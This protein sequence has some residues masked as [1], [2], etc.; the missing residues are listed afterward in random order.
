MKAK[1]HETQEFAES[2]W[3]VF[4]SA[5]PPTPL[6]SAFLLPEARPVRALGG[7]DRVGGGARLHSTT[8]N[9][10]GTTRPRARG[11]V[12]QGAGGTPRTAGSKSGQ[13]DPYMTTRLLHIG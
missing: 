6:D 5:P 2:R 7:D 9:A 12:R 8:R 4:I 11:L 13:A 1:K 3:F 10:R